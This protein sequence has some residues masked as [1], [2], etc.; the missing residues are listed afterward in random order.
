MKFA[1]KTT[2]D[3]SLSLSHNGH[4]FKTETSVKRTPRVGPRLSLFP[5]FD[6]TLRRD[7]YCGDPKGFRIRKSWLYL[8]KKVPWKRRET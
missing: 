4:L 8:K 3:I 6:I 1:I 5:L 7:T 2:G